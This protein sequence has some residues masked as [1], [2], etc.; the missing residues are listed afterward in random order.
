MGSELNNT[1]TLTQVA[2][3]VLDKV[4]YA[5]DFQTTAY[6]FTALMAPEVKWTIST[7]YE[8][9]LITTLS[10]NYLTIRLRSQD[11]YEVIVNG[12]KPESIISSLKSRASNLIVLVESVFKHKILHKN[13]EKL[14]L[15]AI[16]LKKMH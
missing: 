4:I 13:F 6:F 11:F 10:K 1:L 15:L 12:A 5:S 9:A 7:Q 3:C 2:N 8:Q 14:E 16:F